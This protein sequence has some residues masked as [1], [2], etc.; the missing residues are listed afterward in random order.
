M[1]ISSYSSFPMALSGLDLSPE[2]DLHPLYPTT[3]YIESL[4]SSHSGLAPV[5]KAELVAHC[6]SRSCAFAD[7][8]LLQFLLSDP[9]TQVFVDLC[10]RDED[11]IGLVSL[12]IHGFGAESDRDVERE[13]CVRLLV[14]Q[15]ADR[16]PDNGTQRCVY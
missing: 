13:E 15:G 9:R 1:S 2:P 7:L 4:L 12:A 10:T 16:S 14:A 6:L 5:Q 3:A 8:A 11:G